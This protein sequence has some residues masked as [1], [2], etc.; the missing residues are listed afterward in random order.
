MSYDKKV[1]L[2]YLAAIADLYADLAMEYGA[3]DLDSVLE[4]L[5]KNLN[6]GIERIRS[7]KV[8]NEMKNNEPDS[9]DRIKA[10]RPNGPRRLSK[11]LPG[12]YQ[13]RL[14][15]A[16]YARLAGCTLG[17]IVEA[18]SVED[19]Q[20]WA[21]SIGD[22]FP[23]VD[24]WTKAPGIPSSLRYEKSAIEDYTRN[25]MNH[26]P[27]DDD[28]VYTLLGLLI[29]ED[30]GPD[31]TVDDVGKAWIR[32]LPY[33]CTAEDI[34]LKNLKA[35]IPGTEAAVKNNPYCQWIGADI[36]SDP[37]AYVAPGWPEKAA[38]F[39]WRDAWLS[40]RRNGI[41]GEM[42]FSAV[43]SAA[44]C[45]DDPI[46]AV[47]IG[48]SEIPGHCRLAEAVKWALDE[49]KNIHNYLDARRAVDEKFPGMHIAHTINNACLTIFG[50]SIG[51]T[52]VTR[53]ISETVA[54][55]L[56]N[57]CT[58]ATAGSIVGAVAGKKNVPE[59]WYKPFNNRVRTYLKGIEELSISD[60]LARFTKQAEKIAAG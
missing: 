11:G 53:V 20:K 47:K 17:A 28:I 33:A 21:K 4:A 15:G 41:Y 52:D 56:D 45:A 50:L 8:D 26:V 58:A 16:L 14:E 54:M 12:D 30:Y 48:L 5:G 18:Y 49:R 39:A 43:Q 51:G 24:Y 32:Y 38:E 27:V 1:N 34:A 40:H 23:P 44:F 22:T 37:W 3:K 60:V 25:I 42:F 35:G 9:L 19:M 55:G 31:F 6:D 46:E 36:R 57:D 7:L 29:I 10:I 13:D 2:G 59:H